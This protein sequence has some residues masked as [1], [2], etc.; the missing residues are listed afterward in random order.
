MF[1]VFFWL[2]ASLGEEKSGLTSSVQES[3]KKGVLGPVHVEKNTL[4]SWFIQLLHYHDWLRQHVIEPFYT[5]PSNLLV[6]LSFGRRSR[7][8]F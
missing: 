6:S 7:T 2:F 4:G 3:V 8:C 5:K 1:E